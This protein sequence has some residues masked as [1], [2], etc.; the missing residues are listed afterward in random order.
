MYDSFFWKL[1]FFSKCKILWRSLMSPQLSPA[2]FGHA[3]EV[4]EFFFSFP[5]EFLKAVTSFSSP[6]SLLDFSPVFL[7]TILLYSS[8]KQ[9]INGVQTFQSNDLIVDIVLHCPPLPP[10]PCSLSRL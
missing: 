2:L 8:C 7:L 4:L 6:S 10:V 3:V 1:F 5:N 9:Y